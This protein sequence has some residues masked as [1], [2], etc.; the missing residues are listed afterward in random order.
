MDKIKKVAVR[1][2]KFVSDHKVAIATIAT[3]AVCL[4][5]NRMALRDHDEF[6]KENNL[7]DKYYNAEV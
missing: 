7:F 6:L 2:Q 4:K 1:T 5:L 3:A